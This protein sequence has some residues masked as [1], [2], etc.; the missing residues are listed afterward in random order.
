MNSKND[1]TQLDTKDTSELF[2]QHANLPKRFFSKLK[3]ASSVN[4]FGI[5]TLKVGFKISLSETDLINW[6]KNNETIVAEV[7]EKPISKVYHRSYPIGNG[8]SVSFTY[9][10]MDYQKKE[11]N[12]LLIGFHSVPKMLGICN[13]SQVQDWQKG[14][15]RINHII[16]NI[17]FPMEI[18]DIR[19][20]IIYR[21]D[22]S[23]NFQVGDNVSY[24]LDILSQRYFPHRDCLIRSGKQVAFSAK[25][26][27]VSFY[28]KYLKCKKVNKCNYEDAAVILRM[29]IQIR[30]K[31]QAQHWLGSNV[32]TLRLVTMQ[33][34]LERLEQDLITLKLDK[35]VLGN[36]V[37]RIACS[38]LFSKTVSN[39]LISYVTLRDTWSRERLK[40]RFSVKVI[41]TRE[42]MLSEAGLSG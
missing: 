25:E 29:E 32:P 20:G 36:L 23:V 35:P 31:R 1:N 40:E 42:K 16:S 13:H 12:L 37:E 15:D 26:V 28:N 30:S 18:P 8:S 4:I 41:S 22:L 33:G 5:D 9:I 21:I 24:F 27:S 19:D 11:V 6:K 2:R 14:W 34:V 17:P 10:P 7:G 38:D 3:T 39:N